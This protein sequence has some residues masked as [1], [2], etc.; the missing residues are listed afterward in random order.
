[1]DEP[2]SS[3]EKDKRRGEEVGLGRRMDRQLHAACVSS[4][5]MIA[6]DSNRI[7]PSPSIKAGSAVIGLT[8]RYAA[9]RL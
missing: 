8:A 5:S 2:V 1:M 6:S 9:S 3:P 4:Y 7:G